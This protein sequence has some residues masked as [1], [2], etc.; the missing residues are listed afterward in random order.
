MLSIS[1]SFKSNLETTFDSIANL[2]LNEDIKSFEKSQTERNATKSRIG[3]SSMESRIDDTSVEED[4]LVKSQTELNHLSA[5][6]QAED[7]PSNKLQ[8]SS[9]EPKELNKITATNTPTFNGLSSKFSSNKFSDLAN[10]NLFVDS[11]KNTK[12]FNFT[13]KT[14]S[15][16]PKWKPITENKNSSNDNNDATTEDKFEFDIGYVDFTSGARRRPSMRIP[17]KI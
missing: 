9:S 14:Q 13:I 17:R 15:S 8:L 3:N 12:G 11:N 16:I 7:D 4:F 1:S 10:K 2:S 5:E 6:T